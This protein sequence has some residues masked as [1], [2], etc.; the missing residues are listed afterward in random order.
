M[1]SI[2]VE[3]VGYNLKI[4]HRRHVYTSTYKQQFIQHL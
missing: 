1:H 3:L 4:S 2:Y